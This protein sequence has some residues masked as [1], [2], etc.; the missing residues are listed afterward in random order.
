MWD[1]PGA[2]L[3]PVSPALAGGFLST[4]PPGKSL[5]IAFKSAEIPQLFFVLHSIDILKASCFIDCPLIWFA[6][7]YIQIMHFGQ[8]CY[9]YCVLSVSY[10]DAND[11]SFLYC[12]QY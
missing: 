3:E 10:Q 1:L 2:G 6:H 9:T 11:L 4:V 12:W 7:N 5:F 8:K